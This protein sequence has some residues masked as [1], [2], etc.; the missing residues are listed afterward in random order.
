MIDGKE[1]DL[2]TGGGILVLSDD[3]GHLSSAEQ[4]ETTKMMLITS[5]LPITGIGQ[6]GEEY[7]LY[8]SLDPAINELL[9]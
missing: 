1:Y 6:H 9:P 3:M 5:D 2:N 8:I 7:T 4:M